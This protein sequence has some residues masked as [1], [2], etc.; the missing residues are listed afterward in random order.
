MRGNKKCIQ[1]FGYEN[2]KN[3]LLEGKFRVLMFCRAK[4]I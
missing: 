2:I 3:G 4:V 1:N